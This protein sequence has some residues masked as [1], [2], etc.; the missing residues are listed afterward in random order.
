MALNHT[1]VQ[2]ALRNRMLSLGALLPA[3]RAYENEAFTPRPGQS[4]LEEDFVPATSRM[5]GGPAAGG[6]MEHAGLYVLR[7]YALAES[8]IDD[9]PAI[10]ALLALFTPGTTVPAGTETVRIPTDF[11]PNAG[12][13]IP[14]ADPGFAACKITIPWRVFSTNTVAA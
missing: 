2:L 6:R 10:D 4:Y 12:G 8:G 1:A 5:I 11:A 3:G 13:F 9:R 14:T 7:W